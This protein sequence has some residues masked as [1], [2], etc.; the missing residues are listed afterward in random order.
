M[1]RVTELSEEIE[2]AEDEVLDTLEAVKTRQGKGKSSNSIVNFEEVAGS[3]QQFEVCRLFLATLQLVNIYLTAL[4]LLHLKYFCQA[5]MG[6]V[7]LMHGTTD[8]PLQMR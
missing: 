2:V 8:H 4:A 6:N 3:Q 5:N 1:T 7:E